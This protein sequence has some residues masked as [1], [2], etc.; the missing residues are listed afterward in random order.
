M[1]SVFLINHENIGKQGISYYAYDQH[2]RFLSIIFKS[3]V[4]FFKFTNTLNS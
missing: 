1:L 3:V 4:A 2:Q